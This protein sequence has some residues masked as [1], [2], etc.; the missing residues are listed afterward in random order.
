MKNKIILSLVMSSMMVTSLSAGCCSLPK[1]KVTNPV[2]SYN[3]LKDSVEDLGKVVGKSVGNAVPDKYFELLKDAEG[4]LDEL[5]N[6]SPIGAAL[7]KERDRRNGSTKVVRNVGK[8]T[9]KNTTSKYDNNSKVVN[10]YSNSATKFDNDR[11]NAEKLN[12]LFLANSRN[13]SNGLSG[14]TFLKVG[15]GQKFDNRLAENTTLLINDPI[16]VKIPSYEHSQKFISVNTVPTSSS[17]TNVPK[18]RSFKIP[19]GLN[20]NISSNMFSNDS[21]LVKKIDKLCKGENDFIERKYTITATKLHIRTSTQKRNKCLHDSSGKDWDCKS[22]SST[23]VQVKD[24]TRYEKEKSKKF[25]DKKIVAEFNKNNF[26]NMTKFKNSCRNITIKSVKKYII[27]NNTIEK[28]LNNL[29]R[30]SSL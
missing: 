6:L 14:S 17:Y 28:F 21:L 4:A 25:K 29:N 27:E 1:I 2:D 12:K 18:T 13:G 24:Y 10:G 22:T 15:T 7:I 3:N 11:I 16:T 30:Q 23:I 26:N 19:Y 8:K 5:G 9:Y 20:D